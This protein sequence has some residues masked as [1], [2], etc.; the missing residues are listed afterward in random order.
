MNSEKFKTKYLLGDVFEKKIPLDKSRLPGKPGQKL[1]VTID[2]KNANTKKT[3]LLSDNLV[4]NARE[5]LRAV[6]K[7][8][9]SIDLYKRESE[10][11]KFI[12]QLKNLAESAKK[13]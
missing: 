9:A 10:V 3:K 6:G 12:A 1:N 5:L 13:L 2:P 8:A 11:N 4:F 7:A